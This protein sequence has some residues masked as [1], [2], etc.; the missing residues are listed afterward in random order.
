MKEY[1]VL[2]GLCAAIGFGLVMS[3]AEVLT[4]MFSK[5]VFVVGVGMLITFIVFYSAAK[6]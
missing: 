3:I 2:I 5:E 4:H 1:P 6:N